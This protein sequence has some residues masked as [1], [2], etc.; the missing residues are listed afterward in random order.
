MIRIVIFIHTL[1]AICTSFLTIL[2]LYDEFKMLVSQV[3]LNEN[4]HS[5]YQY[6]NKTLIN[7]TNFTGTT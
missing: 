7:M 1:Y 4:V 6:L 3:L 5:T 2:K